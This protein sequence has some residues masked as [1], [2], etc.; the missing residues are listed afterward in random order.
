[1]IPNTTVII[2]ITFN[3]TPPKAAREEAALIDDD[4]LIHMVWKNAAAK[5]AVTLYTYVGI[6]DFLSHSPTLRGIAIILIQTW[7]QA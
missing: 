4:A 7:A 5:A 3:S 1:M 2:P 6:D